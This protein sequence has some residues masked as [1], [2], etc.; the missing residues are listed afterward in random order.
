MLKDL[1]IFSMLKTR[2]HWHQ[3]RHKVLAENVAN[4]DTPGYEARDLKALS[5]N[6]LMASASP[7][8]TRMVA[9]AAARTDPRHL[10]AQMQPG[11]EGMRTQKGDSFEVT[12]QGNSVVLED[13]MMEMASN[14]L[15][16]DTATTLY[17]KSLNLLRTAVR[18]R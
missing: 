11:M 10:G 4:A 14:Q 5:F 12:P 8:P 18:R 15:D 9:T 6:R 13:Q 7:R 3:T 2:M 17:S 1:P 16:Y